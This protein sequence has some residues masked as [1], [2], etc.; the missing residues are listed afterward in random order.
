MPVQREAWTWKP[1][2]PDLS[3]PLNRTKRAVCLLMAIIYI[4]LEKLGKK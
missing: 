2:L 4:E 1:G 3:I